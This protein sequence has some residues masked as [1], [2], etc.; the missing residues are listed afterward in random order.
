MTDNPAV[1]F[2]S[3]VGKKCDMSELQVGE[4]FLVERAGGKVREVSR[5]VRREGDSFV[6]T[7]ADWSE[8]GETYKVMVLDA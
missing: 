3:I 8:L 4:V 6:C 1:D 5:V 2:W 7:R